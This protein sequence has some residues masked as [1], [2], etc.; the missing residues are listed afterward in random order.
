MKNR[1][2]EKEEAVSQGG[3]KKERKKHKKKEG[4]CSNQLPSSNRKQYI[5][6]KDK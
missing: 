5:A 2:G 6:S 3:K 4:S 1:Q